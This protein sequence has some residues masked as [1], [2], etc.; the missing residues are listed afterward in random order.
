MFQAS[1]SCLLL[2]VLFALSLLDSVFAQISLPFSFHDHQG[3][4]DLKWGFVGE[5]SNEE[6]EMEFSLPSDI[7]MGL[8]LGCTSSVK[9]DMVIG[10][11]GG[12]NPVFLD[13]FFEP[14]G[15][16]QAETDVSLGGTKDV[17]LVSA[18]YSNEDFISTI[19]FRR[20]LNT[21]DK[22]D[23]VLQKG[24]TPLVYAW[25]ESPCES[26][27]TPHGHGDWGII[28][29]DLSGE[30][31]K[32]SGEPA[33]RLRATRPTSA[34]AKKGSE[35][36]DAEE[37]DCSAGSEALCGCSELLR[38]KFVRSLEECTISDAIAHCKEKGPCLSTQVS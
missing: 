7:Y 8:G 21:G 27:E 18:S 12:S 15:D 5:G 32:V 2:E 13:D 3:P 14:Q 19:R 33:Q 24:V 31:K 29:V 11:G 36:K 23:A 30:G 6:I 17:S 35:E 28:E 9:C 37:I 26:M 34:S 25:C 10:N 16:S 1:P 20:K 38:G 4:F 22:F